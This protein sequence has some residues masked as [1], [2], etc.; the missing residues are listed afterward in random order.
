VPAIAGIEATARTSATGKTLAALGIPAT[1][2]VQ[3][4]IR[5]PA[6]RWEPDYQYNTSAAA[7]V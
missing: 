7:T 5:L 3:A 2:G 4:A 1:A 6:I